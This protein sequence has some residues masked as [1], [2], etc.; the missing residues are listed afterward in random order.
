[1]CYQH[2]LYVLSG[3]VRSRPRGT[4]K[5]FQLLTRTQLFS[6]FIESRSLSSGNDAV[7]AFFDECTDRVRYSENRPASLTLRQ[8]RRLDVLL[9][10]WTHNVRTML[11]RRRFSVMMS[12]Q[13][14]Y[15]VV[16]TCVSW[17]GMSVS[18]VDDEKNLKKLINSLKTVGCQLIRCVTSRRHRN[19]NDVVLT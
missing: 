6:H 1:M 11:L 2:S 9:L 18:A 7:L 15:N 12:F 16:L 8:K 14:P 5:F 13:R 10:S 19:Q 4:E 3:F 17:V